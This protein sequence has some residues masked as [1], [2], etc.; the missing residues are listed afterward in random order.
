MNFLRGISNAVKFFDKSFQ[1]FGCLVSLRG[2]R[3]AKTLIFLIL[4][5]ETMKYC[6]FLPILLI[7]IMSISSKCQQ[8]EV[9]V[10]KIVV[11]KCSPGLDMTWLLLYDTVSNK[12]GVIEEYITKYRGD[13]LKTYHIKYAAVPT[14]FLVTCNMPD[15]FKRKGI[16]VKF[17][18]IIYIPKNHEY[19]NFNALPSELL[20][21]EN[22]SKD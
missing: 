20:N 1:P 2:K 6:S 8:N 12:E 10:G 15:G 14:G 22:I 21:I 9:E 18:A 3:F 7:S 19:T 16:K 5:F 11:E 17:S 4:N 13:T